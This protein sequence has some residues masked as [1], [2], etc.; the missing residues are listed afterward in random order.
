[1]SKRQEQHQEEENAL[2]NRLIA[3]GH[4]ALRLGL[5]VVLFLQVNYLGCRRYSTADLSQNRKYSI[6]ERTR[7]FLRELNSPIR[8][9]TV[10]LGDSE[11]LPE[12]KGLVGEYDRAGGD[13]VTAESLDLSRSRNRIAEL[14]DQYQLPVNRDQVIVISES[15]R[16]RMIGS[17][18]LVKRDPASGRIVEFQGEEKLT[19][20]LLE[21]TE[22]QQ[23]K[24]YLVTGNRRADE[25]VP[26][27][28]QLG[29]MANAQNARLESLVLSG[30]QAV[31]SDADA[32]FFPGNT[33]DLTARE[34]DMVKEFWEERRGGLVILLDPAAE[35][36]NLE[37]ILRENGVFPNGDR[38][39]TVRSI[40]GLGSS[41]IYNAPVTIRP[42]TGPTR[43]LPILALQLLDRTES[44]KVMHE[45]DLYLAQNIRPSPLMVTDRYFWG[46]T[47]FNAE[48]VSY[49]PDIDNGRPDPVFA[50]AS[51]EK[52]APG[53]A[54]LEKGS[55][56]LVVVGNP[57][58]IAP[59]GNTQKTASD[60]CMA[61]LNWVMK[62]DQLMGI[63]PRK[64]ASFNLF[65]PDSTFGLLQTLLI[66]AFPSLLLFCGALV[67]YKRRA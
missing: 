25:L 45:D 53:D 54:G 33:T 21:V 57:N 8:I 58:L 10:F 38:I 50:A 67:W 13:L 60:F 37:S 3:V 35:T 46:E 44:L 31:P 49:E 40:P 32:L 59:D 17:E 65:I 19:A 18:E 66:W 36:P 55:S 52:G 47:D 22:Q 34:A 42:G 23:K 5:L 56:R 39:M 16:V 26:I 1:M 15:G 61:S 14:R 7:G 20:A 28:Q 12:V 27:A 6:S 51:V 43:D 30:R 62:R 9:V 11:I 64:T 48:V 24:M 2:R 41:K 63:A 4:F 29:E